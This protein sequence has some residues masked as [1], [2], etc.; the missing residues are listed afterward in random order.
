[1]KK[2]KSLIITLVSLFIFFSSCIKNDLPFP[3][4]ESVIQEIEVSDMIEK[5]EINTNNKTVNIK[6]GDRANLTKLKITKL[7]VTENATIIPDKDACVNFE[8]FPDFSFSSLDTLPANANTAVNFTDPLSLVLHTYQ[9]H[10]WTINVKKEFSQRNIEV[11]NQIGE[12][13]IDER[14]KRVII[15]VGVDTPYDNVN[16]KSLNLEGEG[17]VAVPDPTTVKDF[18]RSRTFEY[19]RDDELVSTW[20]VDIQ[21]LNLSV[22]LGE[23]SAWATWAS[24]NGGM[25]SGAIPVVEY[26]KTV[27]T[28]W[29]ILPQEYMTVGTSSYEAKLPKL[30]SGTEYECRVSVGE[31]Y[32]DIVKFTTETIEQIPNMNF[33]TWT[34]NGKNWY[35]NSDASDSYWAS[36]NSGVTMSP[37]PNKDA[38]TVKTSDAVSGSAAEM[39][40]ITG[41]TLVGAAAGNLFIGEYKTNM[42]NP[43]AS[44]TFGRAY[45]GARPT[46]LKGFYKY[47]SM[48]IN[49][50]TYP[51]DLV[52]DEC[53]IYLKLWDAAGNEFAY[54]EFIGKETITEYAPFEFDIVY[55]DLKAK[56]AKISIVATSSHYGGY[57]EG[58]KVT[59]QV[60]EG[61]TLWVDE[62]ELSYE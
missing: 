17:A 21:H 58:A 6:V 50:G 33:D 8:Q 11:E 35:A 51:G 36:G 43:S 9:D 22:T 54:G 1:M 47:K 5:A 26:K 53:H 46:K 57:F 56:P 32:T 24:L 45:T 31:D 37:L 30:N 23:I 25:R 61:S 59:G 20:T 29:S 27:D 14:N 15:Y 18:T 34:Q 49:H 38:I 42:S 12:P 55:K 7:V 60:G 13:Q 16:I 2:N 40:T 4:L 44:V 10:I 62:F 19:Y 3:Y 52:N 48:P 39:H 28:E 41:I